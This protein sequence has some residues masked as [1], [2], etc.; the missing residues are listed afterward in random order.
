[1]RAICLA[2]NVEVSMAHRA[3]IAA[4]RPFHSSSF[5]CPLCLSLNDWSS[6]GETPLPPLKQNVG[7]GRWEGPVWNNYKTCLYLKFMKSLGRLKLIPGFSATVNNNLRLRMREKIETWRVSRASHAHS[8]WLIT[9]PTHLPVSFPPQEHDTVPL[10][11]S[12]QP[13]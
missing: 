1:M 4:W 11:K 2:R 5:S 3:D 8:L 12:M 9:S 7:V 13:L 6:E 10:S